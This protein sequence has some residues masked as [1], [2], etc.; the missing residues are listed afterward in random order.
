MSADWELLARIVASPVR[1]AVVN[2][3]LVDLRVH[4]QNMSRDLDLLERDMLRAF[5]ITF[6][7]EGDRLQPLRRPAYGS[8]HRMLSGSFAH[9]GRPVRAAF[10]AICGL[11]RNP[12]SVAEILRAAFRWR[13]RTRERSGPRS[14]VG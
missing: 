4:D 3:P 9:N 13:R 7:R 11:W 1:L 12:L 8:L 14:S 5:E 2:E 10:H 6:S